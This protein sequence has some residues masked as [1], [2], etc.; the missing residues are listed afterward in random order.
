MDTSPIGNQPTS[1]SEGAIQ[2]PSSYRPNEVEDAFTS[3][4]DQSKNTR[5][6][7]LVLAS[8][9]CFLLGYVIGRR[10][11]ERTRESLGEHVLDQLQD[12]LGQSGRAIGDLKAPLQESLRG[13]GEAIGD[14]VSKAVSS[15]AVST[16]SG[17]SSKAVSKLSEMINPKK[18]K[19]LGI[20]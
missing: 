16:L 8:V 18:P 5:I 3:V 20:F 17:T 7:T 12:W 2:K 10:E 11:E 13:S 1:G 19:F 15:K 9:V 14:V 4:D 6:A